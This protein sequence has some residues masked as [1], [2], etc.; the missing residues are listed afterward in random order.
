DLDHL[1]V[2]LRGTAVGAGPV[3]GDV[4]PAGPGL[5]AVLRPA[6]GLVV[7]ESALQAAVQLVGG[8]GGVHG[9]LLRVRGCRMCAG[10]AGQAGRKSTFS[11]TP[12]SGQAQSSGTSDQAVPAGKPSWGSPAA[13]SNR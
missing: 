12:Q 4:V 2:G 3:V 5:D 1:E 8:R 7:L 11:R 9:V 13:S 10:S 6:L